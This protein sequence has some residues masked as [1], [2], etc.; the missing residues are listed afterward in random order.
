MASQLIRITN[1][2]TGKWEYLVQDKIES[3][4]KA[5]VPVGPN[6]KKDV[7]TWI[8]M[9]GRDEAYPAYESV[10][11]FLNKFPPL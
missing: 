9:V 11:Y 3:F 4:Y 1:S 6:Y 2:Y 10:E 8:V 5:I 7:C